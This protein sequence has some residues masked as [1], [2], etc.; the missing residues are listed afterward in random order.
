MAQIEKCARKEGA[1][2][3]NGGALG[4]SIYYFP[5]PIIVIYP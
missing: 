2:V 1:S 3:G 4:F 5:F